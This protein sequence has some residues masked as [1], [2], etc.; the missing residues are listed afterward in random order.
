M[1]NTDRISVTLLVKD[2]ESTIEQCLTALSAFGEVVVLD[3]GSTDST[4]S[5][6]S[7]F[8]QSTAILMCITRSF[9]ASER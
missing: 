1:K 8:A 5:I 7:D 2:A 4:L 3:N 6:V 9:S